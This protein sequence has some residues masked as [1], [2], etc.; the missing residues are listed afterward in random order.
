MKSRLEQAH[1]L[2]TVFQ[3]LFQKKFGERP[4]VNRNKLKYLISDALIDIKPLEFKQL[5][6]YY[7]RIE[8]DPALID[9]CYNYAEILETKK[10]NEE[11]VDNRRQLMRETEL[12]TKEFRERFSK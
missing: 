7:M 12:R 6:E 2:I 11:D 9:L 3:D 4:I 5:I 1:I 10:R 8:S